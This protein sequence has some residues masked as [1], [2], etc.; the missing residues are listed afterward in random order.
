MV[1]MVVVVRVVVL[2]ADQVPGKRRAAGLGCHLVV[3]AAVAAVAAVAA[4]AAAVF[5]AV[6]AL[7]PC[8]SGEKLPAAGNLR[9]CMLCELLLEHTCVHMPTPN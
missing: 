1:P 9:V 6:Y 8:V 2:L 5:F 4:E 7:H 3:A